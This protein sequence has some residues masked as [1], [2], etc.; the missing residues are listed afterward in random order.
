QASITL[1]ATCKLRGHSSGRPRGWANQSMSRRRDAIA[2]L[3]R[4]I[5]ACL[6][7]DKAPSAFIQRSSSECRE[8]PANCSI[9]LASSEV[10]CSPPRKMGG[11]KWPEVLD[12]LDNY[13]C[14]LWLRR[15]QL[16]PT[17]RLTEPRRYQPPCWQDGAEPCLPI[18]SGA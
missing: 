9:A 16:R 11:V 14:R 18:Q 10:N 17:R 12:Y 3:P 2:D 5:A 4:N 6:P 13:N 1:T 8:R 7:P 15:V